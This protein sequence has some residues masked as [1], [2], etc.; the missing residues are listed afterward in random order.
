MSLGS[1]SRYACIQ[2]ASSLH[3]NSVKVFLGNRK[4]AVKVRLARSI[5]VRVGNLRLRLGKSQTH[6]LNRTADS[7][8]NER[9]SSA[10]SSGFKRRVLD[11]DNHDKTKQLPVKKLANRIICLAQLISER[12]FYGYQV[13][14]GYRIVESLLLHDGDIITALIS[15][16]S[17]K[18]ECL[19]AILAAIAVILPNL[20][21][22]FPDDW[23]LNITD[24]KGVYRGYSDGVKIG[25]YAPRLEQANIMFD[26]I[27]KWLATESGKQ[28]LGELKITSTESNGDRIRLSN[29]SRILC[30]SASEQSKIEGETHHLLVLE[31]AQDISDTKVRKS[32][33]PMVSS[34][35]GSI[36]KIGTANTKKCDFYEA[37]KTNERME[38]LTG[39]RSNFFYPYQITT[40]YNSLYRRYVDR[41]KIN[42]G[43]DSD[44][45]RMSYGCEWIFERGMFTTQKQLFNREIAQSNGLFSIRHPRGLHKLLKQYS[46]VVGIDWGASNDSTVV[47]IMAVDWNNPE[48]SGEYHDLSGLHDYTF[49]K[50][51]VL[52]WIEFI[53]DNYEYQ[54]NRIY[55]FLKGLPGLKKVVTDANTAGKP[56]FDR[57]SAAFAGSGVEIVD[58]NFQ[59]SVKSNGYKSLYGDICGK[60]I[61]FP[62]SVEVRRTKEWRKFVNQMLDLQK[63]YKQGLMIVNHPDNKEAHDDYPD[64]LMLASEGCSQP[65]SGLHVESSYGNPFYH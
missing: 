18:T 5:K 26:R 7:V 45:F 9:M 2:A 38:A 54:W 10:S 22:T 53:G 62:C 36:V 64:S 46:I 44:E 21:K 52:D 65:I 47:T 28:I 59:S 19:S 41:E 14:L 63:D 57:M 11:G 61:T 27:K 58:F 42:L 17:G 25:I 13:E 23:K 40:R 43:E 49:Y 15:R 37:I 34:L 56:I 35:L 6:R 12:V 16:Q 31:E 4:K 3:V 24:E 39:K 33:H 32:L 8:Y 60:R 55:P 51:H 30:Q 50:K 48:E 1:R 20:A 29:G